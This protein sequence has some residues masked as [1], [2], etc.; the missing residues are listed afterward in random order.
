MNIVVLGA[1]IAGLSAA[2]EALKLAPAANVYVLEA[3]QR[4]GGLMH[5][6]QV[7]GLLL[8]HG[9][10]SFVAS[11]PDGMSLVQELGLTQ[12]V[13]TGTGAPRV[14]FVACGERLLPLPRGLLAFSKSAPLEILRTPLLSVAGKVRALSEP[15]RRRRKQAG[16]ESLA[17]FV[18]RRFGPELLERVIEP[19]V[20]SVY[21]TAPERLS[22]S[23][24]MPTLVGLEQTHGSVGM[25]LMRTPSPAEAGARL[26]SLAR[27]M[28]S[29]PNRLA[30]RLQGHVFLGARARRIA[31]A[32]SGFRIETQAGGV[33]LADRL[34][35][36][37]PAHVAASLCERL[38]ADLARELAGIEYSS[39]AALHFAFPRKRVAHAMQGTGFVVP[40][41]EKR[42]ISACTW[43]SA[44]W[45]RRAPAETA[46]VRCFL[47]DTEG[48][49][50]AL[51]QAALSDLRDYMGVETA[52]QLTHVLRMARALP[53]YT[54]EHRARE[55]RI[56]RRL[57]GIEGLA[58]CGNTIGGMGVP[59]CIGSGKRAARKLLAA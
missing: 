31:R 10:D 18:T 26:V 33:L 49:E 1:G 20:G 27:G 3:S 16:E 28:G 12:H 52:P 38:D 19:L 50:R 9:P 51:I 40:L 56:E 15:L 54:V 2:A 42:A 41:R 6:Q 14:A 17:S 43:V 53:R 34:I 47:R 7:G 25:G 39:L 13:V 30:V 58:L 55:G 5:T 48:D 24:V 21:G 8:E 45:P 37:L 59:E 46:L 11:K 44:K 29:L 57:A 35:V 22:A 23:A 4:V 36:A 32:G